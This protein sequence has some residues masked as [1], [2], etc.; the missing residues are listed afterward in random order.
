MCSKLIMISITNEYIFHQ[1]ILCD[2]WVH[3]KEKLNVF[4]WKN[5]KIFKWVDSLKYCENIYFISIKY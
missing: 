2:Y 5:Y 1:E 4:A 3:V